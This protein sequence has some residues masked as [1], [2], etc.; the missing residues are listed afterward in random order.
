MKRYAKGDTL[1]EVMLAISIFAMLMVGG[2]ALMNDGLSKAQTTLELTMARNTIDS[3]AEALR[4]INDA[5]IAKYPNEVDDNSTAAQWGKI[6]E[7]ASDNATSLGDCKI[8]TTD[9]NKTFVV[10]SYT[11]K[12]KNTDMAG[13]DTYPRLVYS[14]EDTNK[15]NESPN[16]AGSR[17]VWIE[18]VKPES[19]SNYYDFHIRACWQP[20]GTNTPATLGTIVRLY[21]P[22]TK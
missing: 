14:K 5:Y 15:I 8:N 10:D 16:Y 20:A 11:M 13:A 6:T 3:Q 2:L 12:K 17:G 9:F 21:D 4:F 18:A 1:M 7:G 19:S 22:K